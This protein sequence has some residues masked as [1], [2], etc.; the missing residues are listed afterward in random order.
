MA[1]GGVAD[2]QRGAVVAA[3]GLNAVLDLVGSVDVNDRRGAFDG[4][5]DNAQ[6]DFNDGIYGLGIRFDLPV[7]R[8]AERNAFR[9]SLVNVE[10]AVR[11]AQE[12]EDQVKLDVLSSLRDIRVA[13]ETLRV[14][15]L[16]IQ[17][18]RRRVDL[19]NELLDLGRGETRDVTEAEEDLVD[20]QNSFTEA[21]VDFRLA[22]LE[23]RRDL[24]VLQVDA[25]GLYDDS[26]VFGEAAVEVL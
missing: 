24:G 7:E 23:L 12:R 2:A 16:A 21:L 17:V 15:A 26:P 14:Q 18:A 13:A 4:R 1:Y 6:F 25:D 22:E 11:A 10:R 8:T 5:L 9:E 20:A 19:A 3:D